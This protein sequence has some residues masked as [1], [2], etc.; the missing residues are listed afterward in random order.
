MFNIKKTLMAKINFSKIIV[1]DLDGKDVR[2]NIHR[3]L[4]NLLHMQG[5]GIEEDALAHKIYE[6][7]DVDGNPTEV[8]LTKDEVKIV[9]QYISNYP[10]IVAKAV[11]D[12]LT[13][14]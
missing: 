12:I 11:M 14:E 6:C 5:R 3:D 4:A 13:S 2:I 1:K 8:D 9:T 7:R 10:Y